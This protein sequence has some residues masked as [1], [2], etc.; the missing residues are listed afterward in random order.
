MDAKVPEFAE[1]SKRTVPVLKPERDVCRASG[2][3]GEPKGRF[4]LD[5]ECPAVT[6]KY[7]GQIR[8]LFMSVQVNRIIETVLPGGV[9]FLNQLMPEK[10]GNS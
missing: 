4:C 3:A 1:R 5:A 9:E 7:P 6:N 8:M 10:L 2:F